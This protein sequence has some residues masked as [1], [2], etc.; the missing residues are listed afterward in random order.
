MLPP[1]SHKLALDYYKV[2]DTENAIKYFN[3]C[4]NKDEVYGMS[5]NKRANCANYLAGIKY[6]S[7][8]ITPE[9]F[10]YLNYAHEYSPENQV[11]IKNL[12]VAFLSRKE[13]TKAKLYFEKCANTPIDEVSFSE[14]LKNE[15]IQN[16]GLIYKDEI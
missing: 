15:C 6:K 13:F 16:L 2:G 11:Y 12:A 1:N 8:V 14:N 4:I 5:D 10:S 7:G 9:I 3:K